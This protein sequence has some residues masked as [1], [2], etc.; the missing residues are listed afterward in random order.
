MCARL[1]TLLRRISDLV[2]FNVFINFMNKFQ[3]GSKNLLKSPIE[4]SDLGHLPGGYCD[5]PD[6]IDISLL[7][8][9]Q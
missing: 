6:Y 8:H 3:N 4:N 7:D 5:S 9:R 1:R 2:V